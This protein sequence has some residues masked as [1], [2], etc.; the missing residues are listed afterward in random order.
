MKLEYA[1]RIERLADGDG[2][3]YLATVPDLPGCLSDGETPEEALKNVQDA[4]ASWIEAAREWKQEIP[5]P[6]PPLARA[7]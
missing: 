6:S 4:I 5:E 7:G 3:G 1:I 2:G